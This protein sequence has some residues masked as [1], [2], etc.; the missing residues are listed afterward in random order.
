MNLSIFA[1][2]PAVGT[3]S[4]M[5]SREIS[6][7]T[8]KELF[9]VHRDIRIMLDA[10]KDDELKAQVAVSLDKRGYV[11]AYSVPKKLA[12]LL[13][14]KYAG[15]ARVPTRLQ[16]EAA[17]KTI[18]QLLGVQLIRQFKCL[19]YRIDGYDSLNNVAYEIDEPA[20]RHNL[21]KDAKRQ[22]NIEKVLR[23]KFVRISL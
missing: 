6:D 21:E 1:A 4:T 16:E 11:S 19:S 20:H 8:G 17:L 22:K 5:S 3:Q 14:K 2:A 23:C 9:H 18:E 13:L 10:L 7:L 12:D 15:L